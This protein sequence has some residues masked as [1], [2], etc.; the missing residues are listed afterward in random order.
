MTGMHGATTGLEVITRRKHELEVFVEFSEASKLEQ[1]D[2]VFLE[3]CVRKN[4]WKGDDNIFRPTTEMLNN[5]RAT[6]LCILPGLWEV[7]PQDSWPPSSFSASPADDF[8]GLGAKDRASHFM[9]NPALMYL[10]KSP[11]RLSSWSISR[12]T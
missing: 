10:T 12:S 4:R 11:M 9:I 6:R 7:Y 8:R 1:Q 3:Q 2:Q 5:L